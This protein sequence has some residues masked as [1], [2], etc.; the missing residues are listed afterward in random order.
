[1]LRQSYATCCGR[2]KWREKRKR[3]PS[4]LVPRPL[5]RWNFSSRF[6]LAVVSVPASESGLQLKLVYTTLILLFKLTAL[7]TKKTFAIWK[8]DFLRFSSICR[9]FSTPFVLVL[10]PKPSGTV[11]QINNE[12]TKQH[13]QSMC[14]KSGYNV[15]PHTPSKYREIIST[16]IYRVALLS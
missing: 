7:I 6:L 9:H 4:F 3:S 11:W 14:N 2:K 8:R 13:W 5:L 15:W 10:P 12:V 16:L 1:M